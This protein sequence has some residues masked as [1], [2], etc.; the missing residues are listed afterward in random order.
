MDCPHLRTRDHA[1]RLKHCSCHRGTRFQS[2]GGA[3]IKGYLESI[4]GKPAQ[5]YWLLADAAQPEAK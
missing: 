4:D 2:E 1:A 5:L 3:E